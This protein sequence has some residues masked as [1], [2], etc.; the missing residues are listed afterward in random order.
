MQ[1]HLLCQCIPLTRHTCRMQTVHLWCNIQSASQYDPT[2]R[3]IHGHQ[4]SPTWTSIAVVIKIYAKAC[5][6]KVKAASMD[7]GVHLSCA[8]FSQLTSFRPGS[9]LKKEGCSEHH[10]NGESL[11]KTSSMQPAQSPPGMP[12]ISALKQ[13]QQRQ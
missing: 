10:G 2:S 5:N 4:P 1:C 7:A 13:R 3:E 9:G 6:P 8:V 11:Q 12:Q